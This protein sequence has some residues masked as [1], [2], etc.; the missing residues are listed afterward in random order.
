MSVGFLLQYQK[1]IDKPDIFFKRIIIFLKFKP[2]VELIGLDT[3]E[4]TDVITFSVL[5]TFDPFVG[6]CEVWAWGTDTI[7]C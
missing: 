2:S 4:Q 6:S 7:W 1:T 5:S 3:E